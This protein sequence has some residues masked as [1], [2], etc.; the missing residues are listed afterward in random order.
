MDGN[1]M[2]ITERT[3]TEDAWTYEETIESGAP[4]GLRYSV[5]VVFLAV[6]AR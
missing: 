3:N 4:I 5:S 1:A 2:L 6:E